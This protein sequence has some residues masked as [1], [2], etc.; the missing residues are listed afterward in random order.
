M[1]ID[2]HTGTSSYMFTQPIKFN[3]ATS[4]LTVSGQME[5]ETILRIQILGLVCFSKSISLLLFCF[6]GLSTRTGYRSPEP[7]TSSAAT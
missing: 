5:T 3:R 2:L 1:E 6:K 7:F 4:E